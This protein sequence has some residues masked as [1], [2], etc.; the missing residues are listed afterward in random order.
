MTLPAAVPLLGIAVAGLSIVGGFLYFAVHIWFCALAQAKGGGSRRNR[1]ALDN[2]AY[3]AARASYIHH[4]DRAGRGMLTGM[5][6]FMLGIGI[7]LVADRWPRNAPA[8]ETRA[9]NGVELCEK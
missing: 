1:L 4:R 7:G 5:L 2:A 9:C 3:K 6:G 8:P